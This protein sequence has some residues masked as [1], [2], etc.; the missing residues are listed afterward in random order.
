MSTRVDRPCGSCGTPV[1]RQFP[2][3][4]TNKG[5]RQRVRWWRCENGHKLYRK[6]K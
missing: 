6:E 2:I 4:K 5:K 3:P 1:V